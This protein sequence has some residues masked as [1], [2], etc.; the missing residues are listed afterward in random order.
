MNSRAI[1]FAGSVPSPIA[2]IG[3][4]EEV[5]TSCTVIDP[6]HFAVGFE[7]GRIEVISLTPDREGHKQTLAVAFP[8]SAPTDLKVS[9][10]ER[11]VYLAA[12]AGGLVWFDL[13]P[14]RLREQ[15]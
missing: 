1:A 14:L 5:V 7:S 10:S 6:D 13:S 11:G 3:P 2:L 4:G 15:S 9:R 8:L 12:V